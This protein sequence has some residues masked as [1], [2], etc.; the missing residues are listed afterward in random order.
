[1]LGAFLSGA[2]GVFADDYSQWPNS[3]LITLNTSGITTA[4]VTNFPVLVRLN[5][6]NFAGFANTLA[7]GADIRFAKTNGTH[8][9]YQIERWVSGA[10]NVDTA[11]IWVRLDTVY[12]NTTQTIRMLW[13]KAGAIDSSNGGRVF[14][15]ANG[16][17]GVWHFNTSGT[18]KRPDA[19][20][21]NDSAKPIGATFTQAG[22]IGGCDTFSAAIAGNNSYDSVANTAN[23]INLANRSFTIMAWCKMDSIPPTDSTGINHDRHFM[24]LGKPAP[25]SGLQF[26]YVHAGKYTFRFYNDDLDQTAAYAGGKAW[27]LIAGSFDTS[28]KKQ[29][30]YYDGALD[31]S[32]TAG[33]NFAGS[34]ALNIGKS[35]WQT[36]DGSLD[37][38]VVS[39][40]A[41]SADWISLCYAS[42]KMGSSVIS[43]VLC[44]P[45]NLTYSTNPASYPTGTQITT[46]S[47]TSSGGAVASYSVAPG[48][49]TG[50]TLSPTTGVITGTPTVAQAATP[51]TVTA[52]NAAGSTTATLSITITSSLAPPSNLSYKNN[53]LT[54]TANTAIT[55][56]T[57]VVTG[58]VDSFTVAPTLPAGLSIVK[59]T[60]II[61]GTPTVAQTATAYTIT[62]RNAAGSTTVSLSITVVT[63][64]LTISYKHNPVNYVAGT[65]IAPD[66][67]VVTGTADSFSVSP[68]LPAGLSLARLTGIISGTPTG[69]AQAATPYTVTAQNA[70][71]PVTVVLS[72]ALCAPPAIQS[73][74]G[75][76]AV[77]AGKN[78]PFGVTATGSGITY[79]WL[80]QLAGK[81]TWDTIAQATSSTYSLSP[82]SYSDSG[83]I[84][85]CAIKGSCGNVTSQN[86]TLTV[87]APVK[88]AIWSRDS[89]GPAPLTTQFNDTSTGSYVNRVWDFGD[90]KVDSTSKSPSHTFGSAGTFVVKLTV[91]GNG[92]TDSTSKKI[93]T[94]APGTNPLQMSGKYLMTKPAGDSQKVALLIQN[95]NSI[96]P[97]LLVSV[98]SIGLWCLAG[99]IPTSPDSSTFRKKYLL[100]TLGSQADGKQYADT[101]MVPIVP[102][103]CGF[104]TAIFWS[105]KK[106]TPFSGG[107]G[108]LVLMKDTMPPTNG[109]SLAGVFVPNDTARLYVGNISSI[110]TN[111]VDS[112][113]I[114]YSLTNDSANFKDK[115]FTKM[116]SMQEVTKAV[117]NNQYVDNIY[118]TS[119][120]SA[121]QTIYYAVMVKGKNDLSSP[122]KIDSL[123]VG[124]DRPVNPITLQAKALSA[125][126]VRLSWNNVGAAGVDRIVI[127][128]RKTTPVDTTLY[129]QSAQKLDSLSPSVID[130]VIIG[131]NFNEKTMYYFGAQ[132][133]K[134]ALGSKITTKA[135]ARD[136]TPA[137]GAPFDSTTVKAINLTRGGPL[138]DTSTNAIRIGWT[139]NRSAVDSL[140]IGISYST[141]SAAAD[142]AVRQVIVQPAGNTDTVAVTLYEDLLFNTNYYVKL[143]L[144]RPGGSWTDPG[145][146]S[147][148]I[149][150]T[151]PF[152]WQSITYFTKDPDSVYALNGEIRVMNQPGDQSKTLN[153]V[154]YFAPPPQIVTG[155]TQVSVGGEFTVKDRGTPFYVGLKID[156]IPS[157]FT[158]SDVRIYRD[159]A[160]LLLLAR[161]PMVDDTVNRYVSIL[162]NDLDFP[163]VA[164]VDRTAPSCAPLGQTG[165]PVAAAKPVNDTVVVHDNIAN[166][167][168]MYLC[169]RGG[170]P[171]DTV[172]SGVLND[173]TAT[174]NLTIDSNFVTQDNGARAL[175]IVTD[176]VHFDTVNLSRSVLRDGSDI[177]FTEAEKW[178]PLSVTAVLDSP[179]AKS[180]LRDLSVSAAQWK[181]DD[182]KFRIFRCLP[183]SNRE[184]S[185]KWMEYADADSQTFDFMLG[186]IVWVKTAARSTV[187][188]GHSHTPSLDS[189]FRFRIEPS[190]WMD[191]A[192]P[193]K[194]N[195]NIGDILGATTSPTGGGATAGAGF[196]VD[197]LQI[198]QWKK[199]VGKHEYASELV[200]M[201][202][203]PTP[204]FNNGATPLFGDG[205]GYTLFNPTLDTIILNVPPLPVSLSHQGLQ[206]KKSAVAG[207]AIR[208]SSS[209]D[210]GTALSSVYCGYSQDK[211]GGVSYYPQAPSFGT[212]HVGVFDGAKRKVFGQAIAHAM[213]EGGYAYVLTFVNEG[214]AKQRITYH[215]DNLT[216]VPQSLRAAV[217][218]AV[219]GTFEDF[220]KGDAGVSVDAGSKE[221]RWLLVGDA[222]YLAKAKMIARP[223]V[224]SLVGTYPNPFRGM[225]RIRYS[226]PYDGVKNLKFA[227][228]NLSGRT[229]WSHEIRDVSISGVS[230]LF[231]NGM[232]SDGRPVAAGIYL[233]RMTALNAAG[234]KPTGVF[235]RKMTFMP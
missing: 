168:W 95:V 214:T 89:A 100:S 167:S 54:C 46:N 165:A 3:A 227:I 209:D 108:V 172:M 76:M 67:P 207:W 183:N 154:R 62:A 125:T 181:Y 210:S 138:F 5:P 2:S 220:S 216:A 83:S 24:G 50:L 234:L 4:N 192:V 96:T 80:R 196:P 226:L 141:A 79:Q 90:G 230:D 38:V 124:L 41:R 204:Q 159:S 15:T 146:S 145:Q 201:K 217:Y 174:L 200:F 91:W 33:H 231:W 58:T 224:L 47:P 74:I 94:W 43:S 149:V 37:E 158:I 60:G 6:G 188:Y 45:F 179:D 111:N 232:A 191:F 102:N 203:N 51:Y 190:A 61:T 8:L 134:G 219:S 184:P 103:Y 66:T 198:Y 112:M 44:S 25:D 143:W 23:S 73:Q 155:F 202:A 11:E 55:P 122:V 40:V 170:D 229:V 68:A 160:G 28:G 65:A 171:Y 106:V 166:L 31:N 136:S 128:Y 148:G 215:L 48:L 173:T 30:L 135:S 137:A 129:D 182:T 99:K 12:G 17:M 177:A 82:A 147:G 218:N 193:F 13:G 144:R 180:V 151:P 19:T 221:Y 27:H 92:G 85:K 39:S 118:N 162:T 140:D 56:D 212:A 123:N 20:F 57:A 16:F 97:P 26:E 84:Y 186:N 185:W 178:V 127:W 152:T 132:V 150:A 93:L 75:S 142:T 120:Y 21:Y 14:D 117:I 211:A 10:N 153:T 107:N 64:P 131:N 228:Y 36:W 52:T 34:G 1:M 78:V 157:G 86:C 233:L 189:V 213:A 139:M 105:D 206:K 235:Q 195:I 109:L 119:F 208:V 77:I 29:M 104:M 130:T 164:M 70:A 110:D 205:T 116:L 7:G 49:P 59:P 161:E 35:F 98:D 222:G 72:I 9:A 87:Y 169:G 175:L 187:R 194:F 121:K 199:S 63:Q 32:R 197:S 176:G 115:T 223:S 42:E 133:F 225:V 81:S 114:W 163:F 156:S 88:A 71:G 69:A 22:I 113:F 101:I 53:P 126:R 18:G